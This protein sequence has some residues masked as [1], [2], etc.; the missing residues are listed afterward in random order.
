MK[1]NTNNKRKVYHLAVYG[2]SA[3]GKTCMLTALA[4]PRYSHHLGYTATWH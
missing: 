1:K 3:S 2:L 4:M